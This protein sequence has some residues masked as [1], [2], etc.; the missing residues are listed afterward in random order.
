[1]NLSPDPNDNPI[2]AMAQASQAQYLVTGDKKDLHAL[3]TLGITQIVT[4]RR[5]A[6][7][8]GF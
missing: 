4:A 2:L 7:A 8:Q 5:F 1:M 6:E 3:A